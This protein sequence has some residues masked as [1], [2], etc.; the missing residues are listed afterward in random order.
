MKVKADH[1]MQFKVTLKEI[2][3]PIWR[4]IRVPSDYSFWDLHVAIQ[5]AM[6]WLDYHL[7]EFRFSDPGMPNELR[8]GIPDPDFEDDVIPGWELPIAAVFTLANRKAGY[9]YDFGDGWEHTVMLEKI[10]PR[11]KEMVLPA[12]IAGRRACPPEDCGGVWGYEKLLQIMC[13]PE[14]DRYEE[15]VAWLGEPF[16]PEA[17]YKD[18][19]AFDDPRARWRIAFTEGA[20]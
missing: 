1:V 7:H 9:E 4:R 17:F 11:E 18:A 19:V 5:D 6:G 15:M 20:E 14:D 16:D 3:P 13:N 10:L 12:C 8:I 2:K